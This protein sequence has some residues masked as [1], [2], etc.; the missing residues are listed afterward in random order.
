MFRYPIATVVTVVVAAGLLWPLSAAR[1][2]PFLS[3]FVI[4][5]AALL[6]DRL[7]SAARAAVGDS[8]R[9]AEI[10]ESIQEGLVSLDYRF[11]FTYVNR[12]GE[13]LI[14]KSKAELLG[15]NVWEVYPELL[16]T[17]AETNAFRVL[18]EQTPLQFEYYLSASNKW[19]DVTLYPT[20]GRGLT[21]YFREIAG[22]KQAQMAL[23]E[24][25]ERYRFSLE[26][27]NVGTWEWNIATGEDRWSENMESIHGMPPGSFQGTIK[28][29]MRTVDPED[30]DMVR[31]EIRRSIDSGK[32]YEVEYRTI[33]E[34]GKVGWV[35]AKGR[36]LYDQHTG[37]PL[38][39][40]GVSTNI[41]QRKSV[42][43]G[44]RD[45][46]ARFRTLAKH[47]PVG[48]FQLD[49]NGSCVF[50]NEYWNTRAGMTPEQSLRDGWLRAVHPEDHYHVLQVRSEA[51]ARGEPYSLSYR[52][53]A[54][55]GKLNW[56]ETVAVPMRDN[57]GEVTG[58]IGTAVDVTEHKLWEAELE[59]ANR[60]VRDVLES[61]TEMFIAV[62]YEWRFTYANQPAVEKMGKALDEILGKNL[63][64]LYPVL[65]ATDFQSQFERVM[66]KRVPAHFEFLAP[67]GSWF[68]VHAHPS[69][70]GLSAYILDVTKRKKNEEELSRLAAIVDASNDAIMSLAPDGTVLTWNGGAERIYGYSA[71]EMIGRNISVVRRPEPL[72][73]TERT[74]ESLRRGESIQHFD[75]MR[76]RKDGRPIWISITASPIRDRRGEVIAISTTARDI[77]EIKALEEQLRQAAKLESLGV[78]A[79]GIAH[80]FNNLLVGILGNASLARDT[81][82]P[83][84]N[85][86]PML[87]GVINA[88][89]RAAVL[90]RQLLAYSG[91]GK[92][93]IQPVDV[94]D[95]VRD[96]TKL[97]QASIP[98]SVV[99]RPR[100][101]PGLPPVVADVAQLQQLIMNLVINAA[102]AI[103]DNPGLVTITT[104][105]QQIVD[106]ETSGTKVGTDP[107]TA[108]RYV[109]FEVDDDGAGMDEATIAKIFDPFFTTKFTGRG[110]GLSAVL[111]IV[112]GHQGFI[113]VASSPGRGSMFK[114][115]FPAAL[116]KIP[117]Q[118]VHEVKD[119]L[120]GSGVILLVDDE[121]L[122]RHFAAT[123]LAQLGYTILE[124]ANGQ[125]AIELFQRNLNKIMLVILDL[126]MPVMDG[127]ECLKRLKGIKPDVPIL[128]STGFSETEAARR[129]QSAGVATF[130]QKPYTA[131]HLARLVKSALSGGGN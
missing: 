83:S 24:G 43:M 42:E 130:L 14:S 53:Q 40:I 97:V 93:V 11:R 30:R 58:Y 112:R 18:A 103:G 111:G 36:V 51:I 76:I 98:K 105:E 46:E 118:P 39:M 96:M 88:S 100:L 56:I 120:T 50:V 29:M 81:L 61:I 57:A 73:E 85:I 91:K 22:E 106:E 86:Q 48:I 128:L 49:R 82:P 102:E 9:T 75:A 113:K 80:D 95:L 55:D 59:Q 25:E 63:W 68:D 69:N 21:V 119:D 66:S 67:R 12:A 28:D 54:P 6:S 8:K 7:K 3:A 31:G 64:E 101:A 79:G 114:V 109:F 121:E 127:E 52:I 108:G 5:A 70:G 62:D 94:S 99:L 2:L 124:A 4:V 74:L 104:G 65:V 84:S 72:H 125:E 122:V 89:E 129:F 77:T 45:S 107:I 32:M 16:G 47:A 26:A 41:T 10:L 123:M 44:L 23:R 35:E 71:E 20:I 78:L 34:P 38:R 19:A 92:F 117:P 126:S 131:Q 1:V 116:E 17:I 37:Q 15:R 13:I 87:D 27:A 110:L 60:R 90:T 33:V 115:F